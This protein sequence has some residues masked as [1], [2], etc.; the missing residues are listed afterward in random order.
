MTRDAAGE[1]E[2][3]EQPLHPVLVL[4]DVRVHFAVGALQ[5][6]VG[7]DAWT[8]VARTRDVDHVQVVRVDDAVQMGVDEVQPRR[9]AP[10]AEQARFDVR[11]GEPFLQQRIVVQIDLAHRQIV[12]RAPVGV[13]L[14][15]QCRRQ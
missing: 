4:R 10:V 15:E 12:R 5:I 9:R 6:C 14:V 3:G 7:H 11:Q 1:R 8:A 2:L 13:Y